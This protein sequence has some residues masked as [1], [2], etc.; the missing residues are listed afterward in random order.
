M[1][2]EAA[3]A[4]PAAGSARRPRG[5]PLIVAIAWRNLWRNR[6][7]TWLT[8]GG[9]AF[10]V[11]LIVVARSATVGTFDVMIDNAARLLV[12]HVQLQHPRYADD[13]SLRHTLQDATT[14]SRAIAAQPGVAAVAQ[15]A[16]AF[17]L[18]AV[19]EKSFAAQMM[20]VDPDA[21]RRLSTLPAA[22]REGRY[23]E[24]PHDVV[25]GSALARNLGA[26]LGDEVVVLGTARD[27]GVAA[28]AGVVVGIV[29]T[30]INDVDRTV[31]QMPL[32]TFQEA[33]GFGDE[34]H[35]IVV[36]LDR[37]GEVDALMAALPEPGLRWVT[38]QELMPDI[39]QMIDLKMAGQFIMFGLVALLVTFSVFNTFAMTVFERVREFGMLMA[40]GMRPHRILAMLELEALWLALFGV[41][42]GAA[43]SVALVLTLAQ[44]G[45]PLGADVGAAFKTLNLPDRIFPVLSW[46]ALFGAAALMLIAVP[47]AGFI[48]ALRTLRLTPVTALRTQL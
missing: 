9:V 31:M 19:G 10:A 48:P 12:G 28:M 26:G 8:S 36:R 42:I 43:L 40:I 4:L 20:G 22:V 32:A 2:R 38:W 17:A 35:M 23:L 16:Q 15:R 37:I 21:E 44:V 6:R 18:V 45:I 34:A 39:E 7:R 41:M 25:I 27:G 5:T 11:F 47:L 24:G 1:P 14:I 13:P 46:P 3:T 30:G 33:F 29:E